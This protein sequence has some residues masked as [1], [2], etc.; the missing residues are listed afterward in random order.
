MSIIPYTSRGKKQS[1]VIGFEAGI[2]FIKVLFENGRLYKYSYRSTT[3]ENIEL[4]K[5]LAAEQ[6]GL[7]TFISQNDPGFE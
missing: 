7:A 5:I 4:M 3:R 6:K 2:D 1:G